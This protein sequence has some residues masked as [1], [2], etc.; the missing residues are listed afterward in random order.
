M[1]PNLVPLD[2]AGM[3]LEQHHDLPTP[4]ASSSGPLLPRHHDGDTPDIGGDTETPRPTASLSH[5]KVPVTILT[6]FLG[7]GKTTLIKH[8]L[9][10][11][12]HGYKIAVVQN[13]FTEK[14]EMGIEAPT[15]I[16]GS[17]GEKFEEL[18][19]LPNG[20][21]CCSA[22]DDFVNAID[23]LIKRRRKASRRNAANAR[24]QGTTSTPT[25][26]LA[27]GR[28]AEN[29][30]Q[31]GAD[32]ASTS[33]P[34]RSTTD[35]AF[36]YILV[37]AAGVAN[38]EELLNTFWVDSGLES[39]IYLDGVVTVVDVSAIENQ[40][41][42]YEEAQKQLYCADVVLCNKLD[43]LLLPCSSPPGL[44]Q[45]EKEKGYQ[46]LLRAMNPDAA[47]Y[48]TV[49]CAVPDLGKLLNLQAFDAERTKARLENALE[50]LCG[51]VEEEELSGAGEEADGEDFLAAG[52]RTKRAKVMNGIST[53]T[54]S[55]TMVM[56]GITTQK[57]PFFLSNLSAAHKLQALVVELKGSLALDPTLF[58]RLV[59]K[60][61]WED[62]LR[63]LRAKGIFCFQGT[64]YSFQLVRELYEVVEVAGRV[65]AGA[66]D[67]SGDRKALAPKFLFVVPAAD[68]RRLREQLT[69]D[70]QGILG[71]EAVE[72][73]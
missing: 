37:E 64:M 42:E 21:I 70:L 54:V 44:K 28:Q 32:G 16:D 53:G 45:K 11:K 22:K 35:L 3:V 69:A 12:R 14:N 9:S 49:K 71:T 55:E 20:C 27:G 58:E 10:D 40:L 68:K 46:N 72:A 25:T 4:S 5:E 43:L 15:L 66:V 57:S 48:S 34:G 60:W 7:S 18:Y 47:Y 24:A 41:A 8:I 6:G 1:V 2:A 59:G 65:A 67:K 63:L 23:G 56:N 50:F 73:I 26:G 62:E 52:E 33:P 13:E 61:L 19:E 39:E 30:A 38:P 31:A 17:T 29:Q 36:D 51:E